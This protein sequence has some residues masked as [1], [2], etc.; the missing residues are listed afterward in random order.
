MFVILEISFSM[1][2]LNDAYSIINMQALRHN[3]TEKLY[4]INKITCFQKE[5]GKSD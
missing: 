2:L 1:V 5:I 3:N 4:E